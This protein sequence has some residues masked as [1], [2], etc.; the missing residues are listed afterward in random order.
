MTPVRLAAIAFIYG[1][2][3][4]AWFA[5]GVSVNERSGEFDQRL[6]Q[7]VALLWGGEHVQVAPRIWFERPKTVTRTSNGL[8]RQGSP[9]RSR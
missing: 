2:A 8:M 3:T 9:S 1:V 6:S 5:L 7:A 4:L